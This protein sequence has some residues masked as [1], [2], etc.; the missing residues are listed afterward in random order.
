MISGFASFNFFS[1]LRPHVTAIFLP[2]LCQM[3]V[4][5]L[6]D[7]S[8]QY[9]V[10]VIGGFCGSFPEATMYT[11]CLVL[12]PIRGLH[13]HPENPIRVLH[14]CLPGMELLLH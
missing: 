2:S 4:P 7:K 13:G 9:T 6:S 8:V 12:L 1:E 11:A 5:R 14:L 10:R 3:T